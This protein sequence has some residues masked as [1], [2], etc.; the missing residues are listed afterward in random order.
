MHKNGFDHTDHC[1]TITK[2]FLIS[3]TA[4][5]NPYSSSTAFNPESFTPIPLSLLDLSQSDIHVLYR[6]AFSQFC[7]MVIMVHGQY[8]SI[9]SSVTKHFE[10]IRL[11]D[12]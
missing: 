12:C 1:T 11:P 3:N 9:H 4:V 10:K 2:A 6:L 7:D 8:I 5:P